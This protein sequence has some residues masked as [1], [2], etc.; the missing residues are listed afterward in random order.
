MEAGVLPIKTGDKKA[1]VLR[2][3]SGPCSA[4]PLSPISP[5]TQSGGEMRSLPGLPWPRVPE[6][7]GLRRSLAQHLALLSHCLLVSPGST[8]LIHLQHRGSCF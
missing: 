5:S 7:P 1:S 4:S 3:P 6:G 2:S 8:D